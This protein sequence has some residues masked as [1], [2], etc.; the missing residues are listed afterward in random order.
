MLRAYSVHF[1]IPFFRRVMR[2]IARA[3][4][5]RRVQ[6]LPA[7]PPLGP[8]QGNCSVDSL[9]GLLAGRSSKLALFLA[10]MFY[11]RCLDSPGKC[12]MQL[13]SFLAQ[14]LILVSL[15]THSHL[16]AF[17][18]GPPLKPLQ[19]HTRAVSRVQVLL[20]LFRLAKISCKRSSRFIVKVLIRVSCFTFSKPCSKKRACG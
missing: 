2:G 8:N 4:G 5:R 12:C 10:F 14:A 19:Q 9:L 6:D 1:P 11:C 18:F 3:H 15:P 20:S 7:R 16:H 13:G 17:P